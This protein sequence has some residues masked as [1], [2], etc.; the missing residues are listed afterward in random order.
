VWDG[1][2]LGDW[3]LELDGAIGLVNLAGRSVDCVK[4]PDH[5]DEILRTRVAS[6]RERRISS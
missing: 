6:T 1:R 5:Q 2:T 3:R 4:T